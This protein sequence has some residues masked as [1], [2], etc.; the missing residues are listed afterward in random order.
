MEGALF[1]TCLN[2]CRLSEERRAVRGRSGDQ[3]IRHRLDEHQASVGNVI[4]PQKAGRIAEI[5][6]VADRTGWC[7]IDPVT[8][9]SKLVPNIHVVGDAAIAGAMPKSAF[10]AN[11]QAKVCAAALVRLLRGES[12][13]DAEAAQHLLQLSCAGLW[14]IYRRCLSTGEWTDSWRS[15][16]PAV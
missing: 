11:A 15:P 6:G 16:G 1:R 4:P 5:A 14:H 13:T 2:G 7:P 9:E 8:F 3:G 10:A 12:P